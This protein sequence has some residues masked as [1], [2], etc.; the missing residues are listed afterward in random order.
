MSRWLACLKP[1]LNLK[2]KNWE[3]QVKEY[4]AIMSALRRPCIS[5][6][7]E[8]NVIEGGEKASLLKFSF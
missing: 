8:E 5:G 7:L 2:I 3:S 4:L 1:K 6:W